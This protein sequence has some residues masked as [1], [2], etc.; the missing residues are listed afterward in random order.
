LAD[1]DIAVVRI[2]ARYDRRFHMWHDLVAWTASYRRVEFDWADR[3]ADQAHRNT[4]IAWY[5]ELHP[6]VNWRIDHQLLVATGQIQAAPDAW[7]AGWLPE[8]DRQ[9]GGTPCACTTTTHTETRS[10][11]A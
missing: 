1:R 6:Q 11:A 10:A 2:R 9:F 3:A 5:M 4:L 7:E 8:N